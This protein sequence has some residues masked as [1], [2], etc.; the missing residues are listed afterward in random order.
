ME[1]LKTSLDFEASDHHTW[2]GY[3]ISNY[4]KDA[5][6]DVVF[7]FRS[8]F[9]DDL[10]GLPASSPALGSTRARFDRRIG[11]LISIELLLP[12]LRD[13][14]TLAERKKS[15][16][17]LAVV[18]L[19]ETVSRSLA[20]DAFL[21]TSSPVKSWYFDIHHEYSSLSSTGKFADTSTLIYWL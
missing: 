2:I 18:L 10:T 12:L 4:P 16:F 9:V 17:Y 7:D 3:Q 21:L 20:F 11:V 13:D 14:I 5:L 19:H 15:L 8:A 1:R 6:N